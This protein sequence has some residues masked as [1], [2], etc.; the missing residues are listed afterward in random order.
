[1]GRIDP[2]QMGS[3]AFKEDVDL[4]AKRKRAEKER[5]RREKKELDAGGAS[6][7]KAAGSSGIRYG[8]VLEATQDRESS[9]Q[10]GIA[11]RAVAC[12]VTR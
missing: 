1:M 6:R 2:K 12:L 11:Y 10:S 4:E 8:D 7:R 3:R 9:D 5:E